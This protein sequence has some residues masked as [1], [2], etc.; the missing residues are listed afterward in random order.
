MDTYEFL[1]IEDFPEADDSRGGVAADPHVM[2]FNLLGGDASSPRVDALVDLIGLV[3]NG[4]KGRLPRSAMVLVRASPQRSASMAAHIKSSSSSLLNTDGECSSPW[5][6]AGDCHVLV[7]EDPRGETYTSPF[8]ALRGEPLCALG[9]CAR[10]CTAKAGSS[11]VLHVD[12]YADFVRSANDAPCKVCT[13][14]GVVLSGRFVGPGR[15]D[16]D[17]DS[18]DAPVVLTVDNALSAPMLLM[19]PLWFFHD[20]VAPVTRRALIEG[21][22]HAVSNRYSPDSLALSCLQT[23]SLADA[24]CVSPR[25]FEDV[26]CFN[27]VHLGWKRMISEMDLDLSMKHVDVYGLDRWFV[28]GGRFNSPPIDDVRRPVPGP[29]K[30]KKA[31]TKTQRGG[32]G[33]RRK[34]SSRSDGAPREA[35]LLHCPDEER[36]KDLR[37]ILASDGFVAWIDTRGRPDGAGAEV[38]ADK[39]WIVAACSSE[40]QETRPLPPAT[41]PRPQ[42][43][44]HVFSPKAVVPEFQVQALDV[45]PSR[46]MEDLSDIYEFSEDAHHDVF[47]RVDP[48]GSA[49]GGDGDERADEG[50]DDAADTLLDLSKVIS[51][52]SATVLHRTESELFFGR[53]PDIVSKVSRSVHRAGR[54]MVMRGVA[55]QDALAPGGMFHPATFMAVL[56]KYVR[57][58]TTRYVNAVYETRRVVQEVARERGLDDDPNI[59]LLADSSEKLGLYYAERIKALSEEWE[60]TVANSADVLLA[61]TCSI[62]MGGTDQSDAAALDTVEPAP[63]KLSSAAIRQRKSLVRGVGMAREQLMKD[64]GPSIQAEMKRWAR[65][66]TDVDESKERYVAHVSLFRSSVGYEEW[67]VPSTTVPSEKPSFR[68]AMPEYV[69]DTGGADT[70]ETASL[71]DQKEFTTPKGFAEPPARRPPNAPTPDDAPD[72][73]HDHVYARLWEWIQSLGSRRIV[74]KKDVESYRSLVNMG[75][76]SVAELRDAVRRSLL[77]YTSKEVT[78][79][80]RSTDSLG[81]DQ[82]VL[83]I[84]LSALLD[85]TQSHETNATQVFLRV[86]QTLSQTTDDA[87]DE[88]R[89]VVL[90]DI[91]KARAKQQQQVMEMDDSSATLFMQL[92]SLGTVSDKDAMETIR[93]NLDTVSST[94]S[95]GK[96][97][98]DEEQY[99]T[100]FEA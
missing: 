10:T 80:I 4:G 26:L 44:H 36:K 33:R 6:A 88:L 40:L 22:A 21:R 92:T 60:Q 91:N 17:V 32:G 61:A 83:P 77:L 90:N 95:R 63:K 14:S 8:R 100:L 62:V 16:V 66:K 41:G 68:A 30:S 72:Q 37:S 97:Q 1:E 23:N 52:R 96:R 78:A 20:S 93:N 39:S 29:D 70:H 75:R 67:A 58:V 19:Q 99:L 82:R 79:V 47:F 5:K 76:A 24:L 2:V 87:L 13:P 7:S 65:S 48:T 55:S 15:V 12:G 85:L 49:A 38:W 25:C 89:T 81:D 3:D 94:G 31:K 98:L 54:A 53:T 51:G 59:I 35:V 56:V 45:N 64:R 74:D 28:R 9:V 18:T 11:D 71:V 84:L 69:E 34:P 73:S 43:D 57:N 50:E 27:N 42:P 46:R 86:V